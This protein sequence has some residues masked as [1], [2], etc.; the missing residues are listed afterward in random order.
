MPDDIRSRDEHEDVDDL[1]EQERGIGESDED[2]DDEDEVE[3]EEDEDDLDSPRGAVADDR[4]FTSEIGS[5]GGS[6]GERETDRRRPRVMRG[7][8]ATSTV[9]TNPRTSFDDRHA[10]GGPQP[11]RR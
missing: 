11:R 7:S 1:D 8:E 3:D 2:L 4:G 5:E 6:P 10:G 9:W